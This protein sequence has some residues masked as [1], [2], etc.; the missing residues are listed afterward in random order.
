MGIRNYKPTSPGRRDASVADFA[1]ITDRK[2]KPEK[3]LLVRITRKGGRNN[4]GKITARHRGGG[5]RKMYRLVDFPAGE[6]QRRRGSRRDR[7]RP[8]PVLP[9]RPGAVRRRRKAVHPRPRRAGSRDDGDERRVR[10]RPGRR[11]LHAA[12]RHPAGH[13]GS[14]CRDAAGPRRADLPGRRH[15]GRPERPRIDLGAAHA[16]LRRGPPRPRR[17]SGDDRGGRLQ[18]AQR[19]SSSARPAASGTWAGARRSAARR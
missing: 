18:R 19:R 9:H 2:K 5:A 7:V 10:P 1:E 12:V 16:A 11:Q 17:L 8:E 3:S 14:Q 13:H 6:G 4:Q 15:R